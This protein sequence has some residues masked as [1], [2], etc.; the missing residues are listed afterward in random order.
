M[1]QSQ[2]GGYFASAIPGLVFRSHP[3]KIKG[4]IYKQHK[5]QHT[6]KIDYTKMLTDIKNKQTRKK[7]TANQ[8]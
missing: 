8:S 5:I 3:L 6:T 7:T 1:C 2:P 4:L